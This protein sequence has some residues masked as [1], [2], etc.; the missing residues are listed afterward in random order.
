MRVFLMGLA[1]VS[2]AFADTSFNKDVAPIPYHLSYA[3]N[4]PLAT[5]FAG[6]VTRA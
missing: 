4:C 2:T 6:A 1:I 3:R 5:A